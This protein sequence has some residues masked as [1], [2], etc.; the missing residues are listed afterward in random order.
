MMIGW[1]SDDHARGSAMKSKY[2]RRLFLFSILLMTIP[3]ISLGALSYDKAKGIIEDKVQQGNR[4]V[5]LQTEL[6][7][8]QLLQTID[9][10]FIQFIN[11][12]I[13]NESIDRSF[14]PKDF[15]VINE[16]AEGLYKL[17]S[18]ESGIQNVRLFSLAE[19]WYLDNSGFV[20]Q[21]SDD[22]LK[23]LTDLAQIPEL[24]KWIADANTGS[25]L[26]VKKLPLNTLNN[27]L[28]IIS[29]RI[30]GYRLQKLIPDALEE[31]NTFIMDESLNVLTEV[32]SG[33]FSPETVA[34]AKGKLLELRE[35]SGDQ[36]Q[37]TIQT[38]AGEVGMLYRISSYNGWTYV[39]LVS[40]E[41]ALKETRAIGWY[42]F[43]VCSAVFVV[44]LSLSFI[45]TRRMYKPIRSMLES[46]LAER[47]QSA[48]RP[49]DELQVIGEH[50]QFLRSSKS[51]LLDQIQG[52]NKQLKEFFVRKL[53]LGELSPKEIRDKAEQ[54]HYDLHGST[55]CVL[56]VQIDTLDGTRFRDNDQDLLM[57]AVNNIVLELVPAE[58]RFDP[59]VVSGNQATI[60]VGEPGSERS[61]KD[62]A[63]IWAEQIQTT[64]REILDLSVSIG[65]SRF[66]NNLE[67]GAQAYSESLEALKYRIRFGEETLLH[68]E[69]VLPDQ[70]THTVFPDWIEKQLIDAITIPDLDKARELLNQFLT[71]TLREKIHHDEYQMLLFR[72]LADLIREIQN[73]GVAPQFFAN[74]EKQ[75]YLQLSDLKTISHTE[76]W[77]MTSVLEPMAQLM[78]AKW[79]TRNKNISDQMIEIIEAGFEKEL[80]LE[81][82]AEKLNYHPNYLKTVFRKETGVNF[83]DYL[84]QY[85]LTEAKKWLLETDMK[86]VEIAERIQ[87][88]NAQ[89]FIR[90]FRKMEDMTPGEYRKRFRSNG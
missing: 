62:N 80:T 85:R 22:Q 57:F 67:S 50:I 45:G 34:L 21:L 61:D 77:F 83:S 82:C 49:D 74:R 69:D 39:T 2:L 73:A 47:G 18:Y 75:L 10:S 32:D 31:T 23:S 9:S 7:V 81:T 14:E 36:G 63:Y 53:L 44:L 30:P 71:M 88:Q 41:H 4:Q 68:V 28:G 56:A 5:L 13:V 27:P 19:R 64:I 26:L 66:H 87:Y 16:L 12:P 84:S 54:F 59:V 70:R 29:A 20:R 86:I 89:N 15:Q 25:V 37:T 11:R 33:S 58:L 52:Q 35:N 42:T 48:T 90:Y 78:S 40:I 38:S 17:Q 60:L 79:D 24:S 3:V 55:Y 6:Q 8:E 46:V 51:Q 76:K 43:F 72:L 1:V 65:I